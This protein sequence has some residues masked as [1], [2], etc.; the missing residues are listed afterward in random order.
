MPALA[1]FTDFVATTGPA[2]IT[3]PEQVVNEAVKK[4]YLLNR[5]LKG[6]PT[7]ESLQGGQTINDTIMFEDNGSYASYSP[8]DTFTPTNKQVTSTISENWRF[9]KFDYSWTN[10]EVMLQGSSSMSREA[11]FKVYKRLKKIKEESAWTSGLNGIENDLTAVPN[12]ADMETASGTKAYSVFAFLSPDETN[13]HY[14]GFTTVMGIDPASESRWRN[15]VSTYDHTAISDQTS[16]LIAAFDD[17]VEDVRY[18]PPEIQTGAFDASQPATGFFITSKQG[19]RLYKQQVRA[20]N[21][22]LLGAASPSDPAYLKTIYGGAE[23]LKIDN[24]TTA[25]LYTSA[26]EASGEPRY[27]FIQPQ[28]MKIIFHTDRYFVKE[29]PFNDRDNPFS[30]TV[31]F[32]VYWNLFCCSRQRQGVIAP[33]SPTN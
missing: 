20:A 4:T 13:Y 8:N 18:I 12:N 21:D 15:V 11:R 16:G 6:K 17:M 28:Y 27:Y 29:G 26:A 31:Y 14:S 30:H 1:T 25:A 10:Q 19:V 2:Y 32:D 22:R 23:I 3:G 24:L 33:T 5:F 7:S 9:S